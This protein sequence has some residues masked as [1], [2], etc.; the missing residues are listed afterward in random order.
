MSAQVNKVLAS[1]KPVCNI[2]KSNSHILTTILFSIIVLSMIPFDLIGLSN[3]QENIMRKM[4][5]L[6]LMNPIGRIFMF[7]IFV[8]LYI[9]KDVMN[10]VL[11]IYLIV[12]LNHV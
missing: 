11:Y 2:V 6:L 8:C 3:I 9:N 5:S 1:L 12:G 7:L 10:M 4:K